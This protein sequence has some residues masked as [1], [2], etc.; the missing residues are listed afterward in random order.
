[1]VRSYM[2]TKGMMVS[3]IS[4]GKR[5]FV[6]IIIIFNTPKCTSHATQESFAV[7]YTCN[8]TQKPIY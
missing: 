3:P 6:T 8:C 5:P 1:M 7:S 4:N 2:V